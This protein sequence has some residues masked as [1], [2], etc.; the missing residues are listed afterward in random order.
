MVLG[1]G[2]KNVY[3]QSQHKMFRHR[4]TGISKLRQLELFCL[5]QSNVEKL[6]PL[7][8]LPLRQIKLR[9]CTRIKT[10]KGI[11]NSPLVSFEIDTC[12]MLEDIS[13]IPKVATLEWLS[14]NRCREVVTVPT[15]EPSNI[16]KHLEFEASSIKTIDF[17][18]NCRH[19]ERLNLSLCE[20]VRDISVLE[21]CPKLLQLDISETSVEDIEVVGKLQN[22]ENLDL[23]ECEFIQDISPVQHCHSLV[24]LNL[25]GVGLLCDDESEYVADFFTPLS[26]LRNLKRLILCIN[27]QIRG[28]IDL[29][30][31][32][33]SAAYMLKH[34]RIIDKQV[35]IIQT[36]CWMHT[37]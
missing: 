32:P 18:V 29:Q 5:A 7:L 34:M 12:S 1:Y 20:K 37:K 4:M 33:M 24:Y 27:H 26:G 16:I 30:V 14:V 6:T 21:H 3:T 19:L 9:N 2:C 17:L 11:Q 13:L 35:H 36:E 10:L 8:G 22:L 23:H 28:S 15:F 31:T 25:T